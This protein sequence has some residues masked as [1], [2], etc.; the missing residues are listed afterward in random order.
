[1]L[2]G[3][4]YF[5]AENKSIFKLNS[6]FNVVDMFSY[7]FF[8][9]VLVLSVFGGVLVYQ[10][11]LEVFSFVGVLVLSIFVGVLPGF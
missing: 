11:F 7:V 3:F 6:L 9:G 2:I 4:K 10:V 8:V 1:M 5:E